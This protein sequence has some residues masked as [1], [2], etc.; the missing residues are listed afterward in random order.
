MDDWHTI[1]TKKRQKKSINVHALATSIN[2]PSKNNIRVIAKADFQQYKK[3]YTEVSFAMSELFDNINKMVYTSS[4]Y[5]SS[6][7]INHNQHNHNKWH[8]KNLDDSEIDVQ[9]NAM[10]NKLSGANIQVIMSSLKTANITIY[11]EMMKVTEIIYD[12]CLSNAQ[13]APLYIKVIRHVMLNYAWIV[14]DDHCKPISFRKILVDMME[15]DF[16]FIIDSIRSGIE[17]TESTKIRR[18]AFFTTIGSMFNECIFGDQLLRFIFNSLE[19]AFLKSGNDEYMD[20]WLILSQWANKIW[21]DANPEYLNE[22]K[23]FI[24]NNNK[25]FNTKIKLLTKNLDDL[26]LNN[27]DDVTIECETEDDEIVDG[28]GMFAGYTVINLIDSVCEHINNEEWF[29]EMLELEG[30]APGIIDRIIETLSN[31]TTDL[32]S[33]FGLLLFLKKQPKYQNKVL[34]C[35]A[36]FASI[37][38][39]NAY[40]NNAKKLLKNTKV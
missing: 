23:L 6:K 21:K 9:I 38:N 10:F 39:C 8:T 26:V 15:H 34:E 17:T 35:V 20:Y 16:N 31:K 24:R 2:A 4:Q 1:D 5:L 14:Y 7:Q 11:D 37:T 19:N 32:K 13:L 12:K 3:M 22:K 18:K 33:V 36:A 29:E 40:A 30:K 28:P 25:R 27:S